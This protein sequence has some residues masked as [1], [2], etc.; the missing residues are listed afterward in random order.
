MKIKSVLVSIA[1]F[2]F[3]QLKK[4]TGLPTFKQCTT[5]M[6]PTFTSLQLCL[7]IISLLV[8]N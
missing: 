4:P 2:Q 7:G 8:A 5:L 6:S 1:T 3:K